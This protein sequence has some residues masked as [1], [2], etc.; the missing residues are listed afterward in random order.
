MSII[1]WAEHEAGALR[2]SALHAVT[3]GALLGPVTL[4]LLGEGAEAV[5]SEAAAV[6]GVAKVVC[7][8]SANLSSGA[9]ENEACCLIGLVSSLGATHL[10]A[11]A[12]PRAKAVLPRV[13]ALLD[14]MQLSEVVRID[15]ADTFVRPIYAGSALATLRSTDRVK[16]VTLRVTAF[17]AAARGSGQAAVETMQ[18]DAGPVLS[19]RVSSASLASGDVD[20]AGARVVISGGRGMGS[21]AQFKQL[22]AVAAKLGAAIGASRAAVDAGYAAPER[23]VGQTG[24]IIAPE[25]YI[26]VGISGAVQ[27]LA[28]MKDSRVIVAINKDLEAPIFQVADYGVVADLFEVLPA[29][30]KALG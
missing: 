20:L 2:Q 10:F 24:K 3:A 25:L 30:E 1:V 14:V 13:A 11:A 22:D 21:A 29:L 9:A 7:V 26:A 15:S 27:H 19:R 28:G 18:I 8:Q 12:S 16:V 17:A 5:A 23:Q 6:Q 4:V